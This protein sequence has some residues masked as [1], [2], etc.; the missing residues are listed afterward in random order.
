MTLT[1]FAV[2]A[3]CSDELA[4]QSCPLFACRGR[5]QNFQADC[6]IVGLYCV[7]KNGKNL[8]RFT[9]SY[10]SRGFAACDCSAVTDLRAMA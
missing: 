3:S 6:C 10:G 7:T 2:L 9:S 5:L 1:L 4:V 8:Q